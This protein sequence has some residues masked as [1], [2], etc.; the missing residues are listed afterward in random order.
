MQKDFPGSQIQIN[1]VDRST[2]AKVEYTIPRYLLCYVYIILWI[3]SC[4]IM[5]VDG[6]F[7]LYLNKYGYMGSVFILLLVQINPPWQFKGKMRK[8]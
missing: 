8:W 3:F 7:D 2:L 1:K 4:S 6:I 5:H